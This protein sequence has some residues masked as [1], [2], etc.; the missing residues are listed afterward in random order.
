MRSAFH[1][2]STETVNWIKNPE[3]KKKDSKDN[4]KSLNHC[5]GSKLGISYG[6]SLL[7]VHFIKEYL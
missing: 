3:R 6:V 4:T 7:F 5:V 2:P 1:R